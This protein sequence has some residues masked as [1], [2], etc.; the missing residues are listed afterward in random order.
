MEFSRKKLRI[1]DVLI[2]HG[3]I[4]EDQLN[5]ALEAQKGTKMK[6]GE[7]LIEIGAVSDDQIARA[8]SEQ[9]HLDIIDLNNVVLYIEVTFHFHFLKL[10]VVLQELLTFV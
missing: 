9:L 4:N 1:G 3:V 8:L 5:M 6:L 7:A 10:F 2:R